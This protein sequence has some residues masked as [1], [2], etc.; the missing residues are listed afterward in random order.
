MTGPE[1]AGKNA[2][3]SR[4]NFFLAQFVV[5]KRSIQKNKKK[6]IL[7]VWKQDELHAEYV[8]VAD[9]MAKANAIAHFASCK[10]VLCTGLVF[11][12]LEIR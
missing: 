2:F 1:Q 8:S 6:S 5:Q 4:L 10:W 12:L 11:V 9:E 3:Q 7:T